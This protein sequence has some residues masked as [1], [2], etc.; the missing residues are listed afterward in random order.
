MKRNFILLL[1][2]LVQQICISQYIGV[3]AKY[4]DSRTVLN[5]GHND[6]RQDRLVLCFY[7][8]AADGTW[9]PVSLSNYDIYLKED[10]VQVV[11]Q[12]GVLDSMGSNYP[13]YAWTAPV[14]ASYYN[15]LGRQFWD[16]STYGVQHFVANGHE[17]D[18]GWQKVSEWVTNYL[19]E[20][21]E[22]FTT[23]EVAV[24][25]YIWPDP[26]FMAPGNVNFGNPGYAPNGPYNLY[27][28][29]CSG[30][31]QLVIRGPMWADSTGNIVVLPVHFGN[32]WA[33]MQDGCRPLVRWSNLTESDINYYLIEKAVGNGSFLPMDSVHPT[34]N[35][36]GA[37]IY[38]WLDTASIS[39]YNLYRIKA[40]ENSGIFFYS[41]VL[42]VNGCRGGRSTID[43]TVIRIYPNPSYDG[44]IVINGEN[45]PKGK[46]S[47]T[48]VSMSGH[49]CRI[50]EFEH[51][52]GTLNKMLDLHWL[53]QGIYSLVLQ[54]PDTSVSKK[55]IIQY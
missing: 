19:D 13:G 47:L 20:E 11:G 53:P 15:S 18:C 3:K 48:V 35:N 26:Y 40:V 17:L 9:T 4:I 46:V 2:L 43:P 16:C 45:I 51:N 24:P 6:S 14:I 23:I 28:Y 37:A 38:A 54:T 49:P 8:V 1:C 55:V 52:G 39:G 42:R 50:S 30:P 33:D 12:S 32:V 31:L 36:G 41:M 27:N 29:N 25:W 34:A 22:Q 10:G 44:R 5:P 21:V 7:E